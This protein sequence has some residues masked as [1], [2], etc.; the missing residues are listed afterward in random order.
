MYSGRLLE[1]FRQTQSGYWDEHRVQGETHTPK[2][3]KAVCNQ[4]LPMPT[5]I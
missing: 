4:N 2:D 3:D 1:H 5:Y